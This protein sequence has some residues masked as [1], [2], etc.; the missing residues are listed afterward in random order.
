MEEEIA[1]SQLL[2]ENEL[3]KA[4]AH[5]LPDVGKRGDNKEFY[6]NV[7]KVEKA[8]RVFYNEIREIDKIAD[9]NVPKN[10]LGGG[11]PAKF[12][13]FPLSLKEVNKIIND[14][15]IFEYPLSAGNEEYRKMIVEYLAQE[16]FQNNNPYNKNEEIKNGLTIDN[17]IFTVS[18]THAYTLVLN[19]ITRPEDV[20][21]MT[22]P[23]YGL[24]TFEPERLDGRVEIINLEEDDEWYI[25]P[26]KLAK[27]IDI[28][29]QELREK[30]KDRTDYIPRVKAFLNTN[31]HNPL[32]KVMNSKHYERLKKLSE[33]CKKRGVFIIDD[34]VYRDLSYDR[35]DLAMP[36][37]TI[38]NMF[39]NTITLL[40]LSKSYGLA[41]IRAGMI[42]ADE[43]IIRGVR[44]RMFQQMDSPP[45]IQGAALAGAYN[46]TE[47][48]K[49]EY[50]KY[51]D[52]IITEYK[53]RY[54]LLRAMVD[55][56]NTIKDEKIRKMIEKEIRKEIKDENE[57]KLIL[58]G[59]PNV[60]FVDKTEPESGFFAVLDF[61]KLKGKKYMEYIITNEIELLKF[62]YKYLRVKFFVGESIS[63]PNKEQLVARVTYALERSDIIRVFYYINKGARL[64]E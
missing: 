2:K 26:Q 49:A 46:A 17:I 13:P 11:S 44:N 36:I 54:D 30:Y 32:G 23:N 51:F 9:N 39:S 47:E 43:V 45:I 18:T 21:I 29:N 19:V 34:M 35:E 53:Y 41:G 58:E 50:K 20:I 10:S 25:N 57:I 27:K 1:I 42:V 63:W 60:K 59:I 4:K 22:G 14:N 7:E 38:P 3:L 55:G 31:P 61:T 48:R 16:G 33:E 40:G 6:E 37:A 62:Y 12:K 8:V 28:I 56:I 52:E 24:F 5:G 64:L 15:N